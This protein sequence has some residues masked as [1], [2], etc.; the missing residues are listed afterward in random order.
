MKKNLVFACL[1]FLGSA[2]FANVELDSYFYGTVFNSKNITS[3]FA[4][5]LF[6]KTSFRQGLD[7]GEEDAVSIFFGSRKHKLD[8][9]L[10]FLANFDFYS[11]QK[12]DSTNYTGTGFNLGLGMGPVFRYTFCEKFSLF[13]RPAFLMNA[14]SFVFS[15]DQEITMLNDF[16]MTDFSIGADLNVGAR[17]WL[18]NKEGFH[19]GLAYGGNFIFTGGAGNFYTQGYSVKDYK[20]TTM[21]FKIYFGLCMNFGDRG[22]DR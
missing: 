8:F 18:I 6:S 22:I 11:G 10:G 5:Q 14:H 9:G 4:D 3:D 19:L 7:F 2:L 12:V 15:D 13:A 1:L 17:S 16:R 20:L 21:A